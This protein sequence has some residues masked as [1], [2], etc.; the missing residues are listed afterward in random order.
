MSMRRACTK[1]SPSP[2]PNSAT[3]ML[4]KRIRYLRRNRSYRFR[5]SRLHGEGQ[6]RYE[7]RKLDTLRASHVNQQHNIRWNIKRLPEHIE[8]GKKF[9]AALSED[10]TIPRFPQ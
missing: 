3:T 4:A 6:G 2:L 5:Q 10:I 9:H 8:T 1:G 7:V